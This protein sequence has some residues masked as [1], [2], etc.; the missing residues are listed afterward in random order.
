VSYDLLVILGIGISL[1][2][3]SVTVLLIL[4]PVRRVLATICPTGEGVR[5]WSRFTV[6]MLTIGPLIVTLMFGLPEKACCDQTAPAALVHVL[7]AALTGT[8]LGLAGI[9]LRMTTLRP[10]AVGVGAGR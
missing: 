2:L 5:F 7:T 8:F 1:V 10:A 9:G 4:E 3:S 6:L